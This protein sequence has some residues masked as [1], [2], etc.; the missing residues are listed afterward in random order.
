[1]T[2]DTIYCPACDTPLDVADAGDCPA[3]PECAVRATCSLCGY[4]SFA[5]GGPGYTARDA[6]AEN[7][8][9]VIE[10]DM[11]RKRRIG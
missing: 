3:I 9:R 6:I 4:N 11:E 7:V 5:L 2:D 10:A 1:M 8:W